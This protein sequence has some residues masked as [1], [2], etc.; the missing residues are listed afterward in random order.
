MRHLMTENVGKHQEPAGNKG[1]KNRKEQ[2]PGGQA[3]EGALGQQAILNGLLEGAE[4]ASGQDEGHRKKKH[5]QDELEGLLG[6]SAPGRLR[7][8]RGLA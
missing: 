1:E 5:A 7:L 3:S 8:V 6:N 2:Y 4:K